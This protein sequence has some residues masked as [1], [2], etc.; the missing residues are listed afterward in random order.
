MYMLSIAQYHTAW[1]IYDDFELY[2][3]VVLAKLVQEGLGYSFMQKVS[4][5][6]WW[7]RI[8]VSNVVKCIEL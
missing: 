2:I 5:E 6:N 8:I 3:E 1:L 4:Y 7:T